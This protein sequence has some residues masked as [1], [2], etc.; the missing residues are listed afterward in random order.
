MNEKKKL[1]IFNW[2]EN[3]ATLGGASRLF[4]TLA[5]SARSKGSSKAKI[6][7]CP[8]FIY[9]T[10]FSKKL[11]LGKAGFLL[12]A[13]DVFW[14]NTGAYTGE[15]GPAMLRGIGKNVRYVVIGHSERRRFLGETDRMINK[16]VKAALAAGLCAVLCVGEPLDVRKKGIAATRQYI[17]NQ[18]KKDL[19]NILNG[20]LKIENLIVAYE[21]IWAI[22]TGK[23]ADPEDARDMAIFIKKEAQSFS[24]L[25]VLYGG[26]VDGRTVGDY[27][28]YNEIDGVLVGNASLHAKE[29]IKIIKEI[30]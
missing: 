3:P 22:G 18:L 1:V 29:I 16:K 27:L 9:L 8:P 7:A 24:G 14:E 26:S 5:K 12:G 13:Q 4:A 6:V 11:A 10:E 23:N 21:P 17:K 19:Q 2:K 25:P 20:K 30:S 28:C 15:I